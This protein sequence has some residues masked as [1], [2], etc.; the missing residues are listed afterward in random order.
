MIDHIRSIHPVVVASAPG[1]MFEGGM[2]DVAREALVN[3]WHEEDDQIEHS[4][5]H[6]FPSRAREGAEDVVLHAGD[7][8]RIGCFADQV[9]VTLALVWDLDEVIKELEALC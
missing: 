5:Y 6:H 8:N 2:R 4:Q 9:K 3:L 7:R 1:W